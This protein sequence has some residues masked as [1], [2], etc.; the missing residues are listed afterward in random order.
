MGTMYAVYAAELFKMS[1]RGAG[2]IELSNEPNYEKV[3]LYQDNYIIE[4]GAYYRVVA[5]PQTAVKVRN[6]VSMLIKPNPLFAEL[7]LTCKGIDDIRFGP[8]RITQIEFT[9]ESRIDRPVKI[10]PNQYFGD[11]VVLD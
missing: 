5:K 2:Y 8:Q 6:G 9:L 4:H 1:T 11:I 7:G 3:E 10:S